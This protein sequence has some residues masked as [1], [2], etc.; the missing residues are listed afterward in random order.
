MY[1]NRYHKYEK[2]PENLSLFLAKNQYSEIEEVAKNILKLVR[3]EGYRYRDISVITK[4]I[5][6]FS[7][8]EYGLFAKNKC[9]FSGSFSYIV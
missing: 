1:E 5:A 4:N 6:T 8:S 2:Q 7:I 3:D 9:K